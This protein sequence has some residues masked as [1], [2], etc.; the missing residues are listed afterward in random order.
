MSALV[1]HI[2]FH[3]GRYHGEGD[4]P[5]SPARLFQALVAGVGLGGPLGDDARAALEWLEKRAAPI[6]ASPRAWQ[7]RR[8]VLFFMPNNDSDRIEGDP[9]RMAKIRTATKVFRPYFFDADVPFVYA[10]PLATGDE[11]F[12]RAICSLAG[13]LYQL[14]RGIDMAWAW[15]ETL[16]DGALDALLAQYP[17]SV[18]GP[19]VGRSTLVLPVPLPGS[20]E[21]VE[22]RHRA[23][24]ERFRY[25]RDGRTVKVV[26]RQPPRPR[27][28]SV[29]YE[30][31]PARRI[32]ELRRST[33][34]SGFA[35]W[36]L[37]R[38]SDLVVRL[39][40][41][42][43]ARLE[44]ALPLRESEIARVLV[45]RKPDGTNDGPT[46][47]RVRIV[48]LPSIGHPHAD[49]AI[50]RVLV[51]IPAGCPLRADDVHWSFSGLEPF[52]RKTGEL[53]GLVLTPATDE[54]M[55]GRYGIADTGG[56]RTWRSVTPVALPR[57]RRSQASGRV[58]RQAPTAATV[59]QALRHAGQRLSPQAVRVQREAFDGKGDRAESFATGARFT[60]DRLWNVEVTF[61]EPVRGPLVIGDGRFLGLGVMRPV[62]RSHGVHAFVVDAGLSESPEPGE[63]A[64]AL[65]RAIMAT[66]QQL[67]GPG[68]GLPAFFSGHERTGEPA[69]SE[70]SPHLA[71]L[72]DPGTIGQPRVLIVAP[73]V[74]EGREPT[75]EERHHLQNLDTALT[76]FQELRTSSAGHL[77]LRSESIDPGDDPLF[78]SARTWESV[79]PYQVTRHA[80]RVGASEALA[81]DLLAECQRRGLP[82]PRVSPRELRAVPGVGL[83]GGAQLIFEVTVKG[84]I[85]LGRSRFLGGGLFAG[86]SPG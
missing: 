70:R 9:L 77:T 72:F 50:R 45:G 56:W 2:R 86:S 67:L 79:T 49:R 1:V 25:L 39:R 85:V 29:A 51:E 30:S 37:V 21:S 53:L 6:I 61:S 11:G 15:G 24:G 31:P 17:G 73:H 76:G 23:S 54:R 55:L 34:E 84:P 36:P 48:P 52:D 19:S 60:Q 66:V 12:A 57:P 10:W 75:R 80:K 69:R 65:R 68:V 38:A 44:S 7:T 42:A 13:R 81:V 74:L 3:D 40:D 41:A 58:H 18:F 46:E 83:I 35:P 26:F 20:L 78:A 16:D 71:F 4:W 22:R 14:G 8:R 64:R 63:I 43:V 33:A 27:F 5:P 59:V 47:A 62:D 82:K 32:Y 28:R